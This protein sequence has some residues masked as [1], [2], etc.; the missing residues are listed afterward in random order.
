MSV[1][2]IKKACRLHLAELTNNIPTAY[3]AME[4]DAPSGLYQ[5]VQFLVRPPEDPT[6]GLGYYRL[7]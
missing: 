6:L 2:I 1:Q 5:R 4:F 7:S 3:E